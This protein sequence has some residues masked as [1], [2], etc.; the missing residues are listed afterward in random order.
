MAT[1]NNMFGK[2]KEFGGIVFFC[3]KVS[4]QASKKYL[5]IRSLIE[6]AVAVIPFSMIVLSKE[7][8]NFLVSVPGNGTNASIST[9]IYRLSMLLSMMLFLSVVSRILSKVKDY[10]GGVHRDMITRV[11]ETQIAEKS[12]GL[13]L[14]YFDS[15]KFYNEMNNAKRDSN[16]LQTLSWFV[17]DAIRSSIQFIASFIILVK[18]NPVFALLLIITGVPSIILE[19]SFAEVTYRW[20][21]NHIPEERKMG[22]IMNILTGNNFAKDIRLF[23]IQSEL[24]SR[25]HTMWKKWFHEKRRITYGKGKWVVLLSALPEIG[26]IGITLFIGM[27]IIFGRLTVGDYSLY[28]G[29]VG[30]LMDGLFMLIT[31][32]SRIYDNNIRLMNYN[33]F[34]RWESNVKDTGTTIPEMLNEI[35]FVN[36]S[37][38]YPGTDQYIL[39]NASFTLSKNERIALVGLNGAGKS[40]IVKLILRYYDP[41]EGEILINGINLKDYDLKAYRKHFSVMFQ[42][43]ANYAFTIRE[44][45]T[46][47]DLGNKEN[48]EKLNSAIERSGVQSVID[49][50]DSGLDTYLTRQFEEEGKELSGGEWQKIALARTFFRDGDII[51]LDEPS[52]SLDPE[53]EH[54]IFQKF[55]ELC[56]G[57][58]AIFISH[59]LSNVTMADRIIVLDNGKVVEDGTHKKLMEQK[60]K[61]S[62][63]F[64]LQ[65]EKY[66]VG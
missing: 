31:L 45:I 43:Y 66:K 47:S 2:V 36:V 61:Y 48:M 40:T 57:K 7:L 37:F 59:R 16:A 44:N 4:W 56:E 46:L 32:S 55:A 34:M 6:I 52:A 17:M 64:N 41:T 65:A 35:S 19:K 53:A 12:A 39:K 60:G 3:F 9:Y 28:T 20:Q 50:Y 11:V 13:D 25:Y 22:Y 10:F 33:N 29:M 63:L 24:L 27:E 14:S 8:L 1:L 21:R 18:L 5:L 42:D 49:K 58:G 26:A 62:Y 54:K 15:A 38:K 51:I 30:Q 23:G